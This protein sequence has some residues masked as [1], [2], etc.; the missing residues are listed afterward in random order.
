[1]GVEE[2][3]HRRAVVQVLAVLTD[4][5]PYGLEPGVPE[6]VPADEYE[7]EAADIVRILFREGVV[8]AHDVEGVWV[9]WFSE[10]LVLRLGVERTARL[11]DRLNDVAS[12]LR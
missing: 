12:S 3:A 11:V 2:R 1:M 7:P 8:T 5:D 6:G 10:S 9:R 4:V